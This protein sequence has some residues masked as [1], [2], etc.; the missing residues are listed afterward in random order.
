MFFKYKKF[1]LLAMLFMLI[2]PFSFAGDNETMLAEEDFDDEIMLES[3]EIYFN[4]SVD[5][6]GDGSSESPYKNFNQ[7]TYHYDEGSERII[8]LADGEYDFNG[9]VDVFSDVI[10]GQSSQNTVVKNAVFQNWNS[11]TICN[12]TFINTTFSNVGEFTAIDSIFKDSY[13]STSIIYSYYSFFQTVTDQVSVNLDSCTFINCSA[14]EGVVFASLAYLNFNNVSMTL[15]DSNLM[16]VDNCLVLLNNSSFTN[17]KVNA[18]AGIRVESGMIEVINSSFTDNYALSDS[19]MSV[20]DSDVQVLESEFKSIYSKNGA[21]NVFGGQLII[22]DSDFIENVATHYAGAVLTFNNPVFFNDS[23]FINNSAKYFA[24]AL[25][26]LNS[27]LDV[28]D[29]SFIDNSAGNGSAVYVFYGDVSVEK[30]SFEN[31]RGS[32]IFLDEANPS[33]NSNIFNNNLDGA[34]Y[35]LSFTEYDFTDN[36]FNGDEVYHSTHPSFIIGDGNYTLIRHSGNFTGQIPSSYDLRSHALLSPVKDQGQDGNCWA[37]AAMATL[38]SC[39]IKATNSTYDL[40]EENMK[41]LMAIFSD[42]GWNLM[43]NDG[44]VA[45]MAIAYLAGWFGPVDEQSDTYAMS[46]Y[47]SPVLHS[48]FHVQNVIFLDF[49][50]TDSIKRAILD[51]GAVATG[52]AWDDR[53]VHGADYYCWRGNA[54]PNHAVTIIGWDDD[55]TSR[56][57]SSP[58]AWIVKNSWGVDAGDDGYFYVSYDDLFLGSFGLTYTFLLNDSIRFDRNYQYDFQGYIN[59]YSNPTIYYKNVF[60]SLGDE[61]LAAVS[62]YFVT[63]SNYTVSI[64]VNDELKLNQT[65]FS[66]MGYYTILLNEFIT[67]N[68]GDRFAVVFALSSDDE[69]CAPIC[70]ND[71]ANKI[72][73]K[74]SSSFISFDGKYWIDLGD[75]TVA[76]IKAFSFID[77]IRTSLSLTVNGSDIIVG[78]T[79]EYGNPLNR[80]N[81]TFNINGNITS[82]PLTDYRA[83]LNCNLSDNLKITASWSGEGYMDC[84][85]QTFVVNSKSFTDLQ[86]YLREHENDDVI[87][88]QEDYIFNPL[89]DDAEGVLIDREVIVNGN[90]HIIDAQGM[91]RIFNITAAV[92]L[93]NMTLK[94]AFSSTGSAIYLTS[95]GA[96]IDN[97]VFSNNTAVDGVRNIYSAYNVSCRD[98]VFDSLPEVNVNTGVEYS[99][100]L[101]IEGYF[102]AGVNFN[103]TDINLTINTTA[104]LNRKVNIID[105]HFSV[106]IRDKSLVAGNYTLSFNGIYSKDF[107]INK[108][109]VDL[110]VMNPSLIEVC[111]VYYGKDKCS[112]DLG[113][114]TYDVINW[115]DEV[116]GLVDR[117]RSFTATFN[118]SE[119]NVFINDDGTFCLRNLSVGTYE[120][121]IEIADPNRMAS[122]TF[123]ITVCKGT[124]SLNISEIS[125]PWGESGNVTF[126]A[127]SNVDDA[128]VV[129]S[130]NN[131]DYN[132]TSSVHD[133]V[134]TISLPID[135]LDIGKYDL[136]VSILESEHYGAVSESVV[137]NLYIRDVSFNVTVGDVKVDENPVVN[138]DFPDYASGIAEVLFNGNVYQIDLSVEHSI[139]LPVVDVGEYNVTVSYHN[140]SVVKSFKVSGY[141]AEDLRD[142]ILNSNGTVNLYHDYEFSQSD[143]VPIIIND[144]IIINGNGHKIDVNGCIG[145]FNITA[146]GTVVRDIVVVNSK[147]EV[148]IVE[149][150]KIRLENVTFMDNQGVCLLIEGD[151][152]TVA[153]SQFLNNGGGVILD[154][155][156]A[157]IYASCFTGNHAE[158]GAGVVMN[159][160]ENSIKNSTFSK[161]HALSG[162]GVVNVG[163]NNNIFYSTFDDNVADDFS[164]AIFIVDGTVNVDEY[165][166]AHGGIWVKIATMRVDGV[167]VN[168][169]DVEIRVIVTADDGSLTVKINDESHTA[170]VV[171][172]KATVRVSGL[173]PG[174]YNGQLIYLGM[175]YN[176][177]HEQVNFTISKKDTVIAG[178]NLN[179]VYNKQARFTV[180]LSPKLAG[181]QIVFY[182]NGVAVGSDKTDANGV[183]GIVLGRNVLGKVGT[184]S[185][186]VEFVGDS[187]YVGS[188][189]TAKV[190]VK[191]TV[192]FSG[193]KKTYKFKKSSKVK[194]I[195][196]TLKSGKTPLKKVKVTLKYGKKK[197]TVKTNK[198]GKITFKLAKKLTRKT[199]VKY[200][201]TYKGGKDYYKVSRSGRI[202]VV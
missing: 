59:Y 64:F 5:E 125:L 84:F 124:A 96:V 142:V 21:L 185:I 82:I 94:N 72:F 129:A 16:T 49:K 9:G 168:G 78:V 83:V 1:M 90:N 22:I 10:I 186:R 98:C 103:L 48:I 193:V 85:N 200:T 79:D 164:K 134:F 174:S 97:V 70:N 131:T 99:K 65:G 119:D 89:T 24:G 106:S 32:A 104:G 3:Q 140:R 53:Y 133:G 107:I 155:D 77:P 61:F 2:I 171:N 202:V 13:S 41:N 60:T 196:V 177:L 160:D 62:T 20:V 192:K 36:Q 91:A 181:R 38:E 149:A 58:G 135:G 161:N 55:Y 167:I 118:G 86:N 47:I 7:Y 28:N 156:G 67:L 37:F 31:N 68:E 12:V 188:V 27:T 137:L 95:A 52:I 115:G 14:D 93:A 46:S 63:Q 157:L 190:T 105:N 102:D 100:D 128:I 130:I 33:I 108:L 109:N 143:N 101:I 111:D 154:G 138:V 26:S 15:S 30:S 11:L 197:M 69:A 73:S 172:G 199:K 54:N 150:D 50:D 57:F 116:V 114:Y 145:L 132:A 198:K 74:D 76:C 25:L 169:F 194:N 147:D 158:F 42:Y 75:S 173:V 112:P 8:H 39:I 179:A 136:I 87:V 183:A 123:T 148:I 162:A 141:T 170:Q 17:N 4:S 23:R 110:I 34:I 35:S 191:K 165:T 176:E 56:Y 113:V 51:Y 187:Y 146:D 184:K 66:D 80:G 153:Y 122:K 151:N 139:E 189:F 159:G 195:K 163:D 182:L 126:T 175:G 178:A 19:F 92:V 152:A 201:L 166:S 6:Y 44:G 120:L 88:L 40:S 144:P 43:T 71:Y 127:F 117:F 29:T 81:V 121:F 180:T 18:S 45:E